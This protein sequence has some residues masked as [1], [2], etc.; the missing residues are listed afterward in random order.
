MLLVLEI[1]LAFV[2][3]WIARLVL[4]VIV[5]FVQEHESLLFAIVIVPGAI[6]GGIGIYFLLH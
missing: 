1:M 2:L 5:S 4:T 6:L 3:L